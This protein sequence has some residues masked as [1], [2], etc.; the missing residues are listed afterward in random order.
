MWKNA[1]GNGIRGSLI[2]MLLLALPAA[3]HSGVMLRQEPAEGQTL[4][5]DSNGPEEQS[6]SVE[7]MERAAGHLI[8]VVGAGGQDPYPELFEQWA[9]AW[10]KLAET[11]QFELVEIGSDQ[12][13]Q[14]APLKNAIERLA[15]L[16]SEPDP[17]GAAEGAAREAAAAEPAE[18]WIV[19]IGHGTFLENVARFNLVGPDVTAAEFREWLQGYRDRLVF[20]NC[21]SS[22][23][24]FINAL[25]GPNRIVITATRSGDQYNFAR[26][27]GFLAEAV[28]GN[29]IDLD[30]DGQSSLLEAFLAAAHQTEEFYR[31]E[32]RIATEESLLDD[33]GDQLGTGNRFF[34]GIRVT[35]T[36]VQ[37][38]VPDGI[39][40]NQVMLGGEQ[41]GEAL[42]PALA[43]RRDEIELEIEALRLKKADLE[44][45]AY[46]RQLEQLM[47]QMAEVYGVGDGS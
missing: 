21:S 1:M 47:L 18:V 20:I 10:R 14:K 23:A 35:G 5:T 25:S 12:E 28:E 6:A 31:S 30:K 41:A 37:G 8:L 40:A 15:T 36:A 26:F 19:L 29:A 4:Q 16:A 24:P 2:G 22:S 46:Y 3:C 34:S 13:P 11:R 32:S 9:A 17:A 43:R 45:E 33:N 44:S 39:R 38:G 27:G 7:P 42:D